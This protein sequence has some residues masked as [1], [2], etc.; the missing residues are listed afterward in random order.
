MP[1]LP[2]LPPASISKNVPLKQPNLSVNK[3]N[4]KRRVQCM[5]C[6]K[7]FCDKGALKIHNSAVHLK[8]MHR[9]TVAGCEMMFSSRRSRNRHSANVIPNCTRAA[10]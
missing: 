8:E 1:C 10:P 9:C 6:L 2:V 5:K 3:N 4:G 7:T